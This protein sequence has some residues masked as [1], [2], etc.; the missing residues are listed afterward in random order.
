MPM[1]LIE[2]TLSETTVHM[3]LADDAD[4][5][6]ATEWLEFEGTEPCS[7]NPVDKRPK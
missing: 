7:R 4:H 3:Q 1:K 6:K 5:E 2:T